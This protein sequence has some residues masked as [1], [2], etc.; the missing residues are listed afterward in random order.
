MEQPCSACGLLKPKIEYTR[1]KRECKDCRNKKQREFYKANR[2]RLIEEK[3]ECKKKN[4]EKIYRKVT[5]E[6]GVIICHRS[7][8]RHKQSQKHKDKMAG[9]IRQRKVPI[10]YYDEENNFKAVD[11]YVMPNVKREFEKIPMNFKTTYKRL[12][13]IKLI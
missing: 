2:E 6:C 9:V 8:E 13:E 12:K 3:K 10:R 1:R 7:L 4:K 11:L 5:C